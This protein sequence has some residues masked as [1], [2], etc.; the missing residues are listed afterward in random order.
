MFNDW[1]IEI[2]F[3]LRFILMITAPSG[4]SNVNKKLNLTPG[5]VG[6]PSAAIHTLRSLQ[7]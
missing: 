1:N 7:R 5:I 3:K 6:F 4:Q 2:H